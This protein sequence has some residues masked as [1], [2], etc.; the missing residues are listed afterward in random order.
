LNVPLNYILVGLLFVAWIG[1]FSVKDAARET[2]ARAADL[3]RT[4]SLEH[5][6]IDD[7]MTEWA[8]L[9]QP[10]YLQ[11]LAQV[12]L[13]LNATDPRQ[14]VTMS[15]LPPVML[16]APTDTSSG[17]FFASVEGYLQMPQARERHDPY[18]DMPRPMVRPQPQSGVGD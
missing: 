13:G 2:N 17:T 14:I 8:I 16:E 10:A 5:G 15:A 6:R 7:L 9:N 3:E 4:V 18:A 1:L 12:N 11:R